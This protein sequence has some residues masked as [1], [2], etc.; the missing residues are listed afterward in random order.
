M[1]H[2]NK[3]N[4]ESHNNDIYTKLVKYTK[5]KKC[6]RE[7]ITNTNWDDKNNHTFKIEDDG[8]YEKFL[9]QYGKLLDTLFG[10]VG[11]MEKPPEVRPLYFDYDIKTKK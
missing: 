6:N 10:K 3:S 7:E 11:Y 8:E 9:E 4:N 2:N 1:I 5:S